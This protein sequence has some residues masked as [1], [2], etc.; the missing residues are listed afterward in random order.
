[1]SGKPTGQEPPDELDA[2]YRR[3]AAHDV[4]AP[5]EAVRRAVHDYAARLA[6]ERADAASAAR[7]AAGRVARPGLWRGALFG[8]LAAAALAGVMI[9]PRFMGPPAPATAGRPEPAASDSRRALLP[10]VAESPPESATAESAAAPRARVAVPPPA[11][12]PQLA[13]AAPPNVRPQS[14]PTSVAPLVARAENVAPPARTNAE[15]SRE[16]RA[17]NSLAQERRITSDQVS[18]VSASGAPPAAAA[19]AAADAA[20]SPGSGLIAA[21]AQ[22]DLA[23]VGAYLE[24]GADVNSRDGVGRTALLLATLGGHAEVVTLLLNA[25]A[26]PN[27]ADARGVRPLAA[28]NAGGHAAIAAAL[29]THGAR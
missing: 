18:G 2:E 7:E 15:A 8:T 4:S 5:S 24:D 3:L 19:P 20:A 12:G 23:G 29:S 27:L 9:A 26:D 14:Q 11:P 13:K 16:A 22:G 21:A 28:A 17:A 6:Q 10:G 1:M 25:G